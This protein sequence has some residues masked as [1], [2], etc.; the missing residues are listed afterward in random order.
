M[1]TICWFCEEGFPQRQ[2]LLKGVPPAEALQVYQPAA[3][4]PFYFHALRLQKELLH[5]GGVEIGR[6][7]QQA[8]G[9]DDAVGGDILP[10]Q[11]AFQAVSHLAGV[12]RFFA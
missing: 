11:A 9:V 2:R 4:G 3:V 7:S 5:I 10:G 12:F 6:P 8:F 1:K